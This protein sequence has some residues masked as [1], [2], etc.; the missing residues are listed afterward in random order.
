MTTQKLTQ[1]LLPLV[2]PTTPLFLWLHPVD[3]RCRFNVYKT[4]VRRQRRRIDIL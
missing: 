4:S 1:I 2:K 3:T